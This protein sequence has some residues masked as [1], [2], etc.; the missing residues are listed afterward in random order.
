MKD[1]TSRSV[2][3]WE[4][5]E[6]ITHLNRVL[7]GWARY[8][9]YGV[10]SQ[11]FGA[12]DSHAWSRIGRWLFRKHSRLKWQQLRRRFCRPGT[13]LLVCDG[14]PFKGAA[15]VSTARY[16]YRGSRIPTPWTQP[17]TAIAA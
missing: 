7:Q 5:G 15:S 17:E 13:W 8:F 6:L 3:H 12:I 1:K 2:L 11:T 14:V 16:R 10:S 4:P 9:R